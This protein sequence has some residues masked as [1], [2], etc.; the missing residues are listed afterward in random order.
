VIWRV[1]FSVP[2]NVFGLLGLALVVFGV[3]LWRLHPDWADLAHQ[4]A[5]P[6]K[7]GG[8]PIL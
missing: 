1:K 2:E 4:V 3:A 6:D 5:A 7:P 8:R